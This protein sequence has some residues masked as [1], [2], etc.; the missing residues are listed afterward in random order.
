VPLRI[1]RQRQPGTTSARKGRHEGGVA[2]GDI[3]DTEE[4]LD[5]VK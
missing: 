5:T 1:Q 3:I 4:I 2:M